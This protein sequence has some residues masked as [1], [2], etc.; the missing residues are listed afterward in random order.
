M[1]SRCL[2]ATGQIQEVEIKFEASNSVCK[3]GVLFF[4]PSLLAQ[5]LLKG[6]DVYK[7]LNKGY[8][9]LMHIILLLAY[10]ALSR[11]KNPEQLQRHKPGEFGKI[12]GIDRVPEAKCLR[13]KLSEISNKN[14]AKDLS[15]Q[16]ADYWI[17]LDNQQGGYYYID[18]H[19]RIYNGKKANRPKTHVSRQKL[20][21]PATTDWWVNDWMGKP[22]FFVTGEVNEKLLTI[23]DNEIIGML[24]DELKASASQQELSENPDLPRFTLVFDREGYSPKKW[25]HWWNEHRIAII[26]YRKNVS[27]LWDE[28]C[29]LEMNVVVAGKKQ[30]MKIAEK[31]IEVDGLKLREIRKLTASGKQTS[32]YTTNY[33][34]STSELAGKMFSRWSQENYFKYMESDYDIDHIIE[35]AYKEVDGDIKIVNP[36]YREK[37]KALEKTRR[38]LEK[39]RADYMKLCDDDLSEDFE[40]NIKKTLKK[41]ELVEEINHLKTKENKQFMDRKNHKY[42]IP[43]SEMPDA[44]KYTKLTTE[45]KLFVE[46]IKMIAFRAETSVVNLLSEF[47][48]K[49]MNEG[50][51]L[52]KEI[53]NSDANL[54]PDYKNET[55]TVCLHSLS[56]PRANK[57][58]KNICEILNDTKT[59]YPTT[60]LR[61]I[62]KSGD[63]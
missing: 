5:G 61:L 49:S 45:K 4:L 29:F 33:I 54:I 27:D 15:I 18:G 51:M 50:R 6:K 53:I 39:I 23:I 35:Y 24:K 34:V 63:C 11:I 41:A 46:L 8:Y 43:I 9:G 21:L 19:V 22:Y 30:K 47:Y 28:K 56:T 62:F 26:S 59:F 55:L 31:Q 52:A 1:T 17:E 10:M 25:K 2:A 48:T 3:A 20:C 58:V 16:L 38:K 14:K 40:E 57:A 32:M 44:E 42:H 12:L 37:T 7:E 60:N 13:D 36:L